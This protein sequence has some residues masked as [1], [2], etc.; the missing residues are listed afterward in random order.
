MLLGMCMFRFA[1]LA[2]LSLHLRS[3]DSFSSALAFAYYYCNYADNVTL[4]AN[5]TIFFF[6]ILLDVNR[7]VITMALSM[8]EST[9][10]CS[11]MM[12]SSSCDSMWCYYYFV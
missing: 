3:F 10:E 9:V 1:T 4:S 7:R 5:V 11:T 6:L 2:L 12:R 8:E